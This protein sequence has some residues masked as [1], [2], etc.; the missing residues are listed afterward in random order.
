MTVTREVTWGEGIVV[1]GFRSPGGLKGAVDRIQSVVGAHIGTRNTF[2]KLTHVDDPSLLSE[3]DRFRAW[4]LLAALSEE[5]AEWGIDDD[6][7]PPL[8]DAKHLQALVRPRQDSNLQPT[9]L[10]LAA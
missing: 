7:V 1:A 3:R 4:L 2:A 9:D 6:V 10:C 5:P 8:A